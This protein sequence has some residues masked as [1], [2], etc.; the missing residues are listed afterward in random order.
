MTDARDLAKIPFFGTADHDA[1]E[2]PDAPPASGAAGHLLAAAGTP[3]AAATH[4]AMP[5]FANPSAEPAKHSADYELSR[6]LDW[7]VISRL[8]GQVAELLTK[9][10]EGQPGMSDA[11]R[12]SAAQA[13]IV[14]VIRAHVDDMVTH[15]G[16]SSAWNDLLQNAA[17]KA[18]F[19]SLFR[20]GRLQPL[21]DL[22]GAENI[23]VYGFDNVWVSYSNGTK[24]RHDPVAAS[25]AELIGEI[26]FLAARGGEDGRSFTATSPILDMDLPGGARLA[27]VHPPIAPRPKVVIRIHRFVDVT[28][29]DLVE[30][31]LTL[32][33]P[34]ANFL[35]AAIR[36]GKSV[37]AAGNPGAG[38]TTLI[39]ALANVIDPEE[40]IVT[41]EKERE[42]YLDR[43]GDKH[44]IVTALQ[45]RPGQGERLP[46][47]SKPGEVTLVDLLEEALRLDTQRII[48]GEVRGGEID[49]MFQAMQ[50]GVGSLSTIHANSPTN[51]IERMATLTQ[52]SLSTSDAYAY[53]QISQHIDLIIQ[54][55]RVT[56]RMGDGQVRRVI[57][58]ISEVQA[59]ESSEASRPIAAPIFR[60]DPRTF[61]LTAVGRPTQALLDDLVHMGFN[62]DELR[63]TEVAR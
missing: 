35:T 12:H 13:H 29:D 54:I 38:K 5:A 33:R 23:D 27:A 25:D 45:Y 58:E 16:Q 44:L 50:A 63:S 47:G 41:I 36:A 15:G 48:V 43:M 42:L 56:D 49:A 62:A 60:A 32:S 18:V 26:Q 39:R 19:D 53:R 61:E 9:T 2:I 34:A 31:H 17:A 6:Q 1:V 52:K 40:K 21:V 3:R 46:D 22:D 51:A 59:G 55:S 10:I 8:R 37:V 20:L 11:Q 24:Q 30:A 57:T 4:A 14:D 7:T 28:L